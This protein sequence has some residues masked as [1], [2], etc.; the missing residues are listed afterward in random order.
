MGIR[1]A[2]AAIGALALSACVSSDYGYVYCYGAGGPVGY[3]VSPSE[4]APACAT[5]TAQAVSFSGPHERGYRGPYSSGPYAFAPT[6]A[7]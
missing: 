7:P 6:P 3:R 1:P 4:P 5:Q 2:L